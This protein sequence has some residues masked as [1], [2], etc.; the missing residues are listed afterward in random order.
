MSQNLKRTK[1]LGNWQEENALE[2]MMDGKVYDP[3]VK[4][5]TALTNL[6]VIKHTDQVDPKTYS[7]VLKETH[8][9]P[10]SHKDFA[11]R[12]GM[13]PRE[14]MREKMM[15]DTVE[16]EFKTMEAEKERERNATNFVTTYQA[17]FTKDF[18]Q[19]LRDSISGLCSG[20]KRDPY[21]L[22]DP[23]V[24]YY[25]HTALHSDDISF[26]VST[27]GSL[28]QPWAKGGTFSYDINDGRNRQF[29]TFENPG[30]APTVR[31]LRVLR[32][33]REK[34]V[35]ACTSISPPGLSGSTIRVLTQELLDLND[36]PIPRAPVDV[37]AGVLSNL[38]GIECSQQEIDSLVKAFVRYR[39]DRVI[40]VEF[41]EYARGNM[42]PFR[43][44]LVLKAFVSCQPDR[45]GYVSEDS[46]IN[47]FNQSGAEGA[48]ESGLSGGELLNYFLDSLHVYGLNSQAGFE[49]NDFFEYYRDVSCELE[50]NEK[51]ETFVTSTWN[52]DME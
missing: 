12:D 32:N 23:P 8:G 24:T 17:S 9:V 38:L 33:L 25:L 29:G 21:Y 1:K 47:A 40:L 22:N 46:I 15:R 27:I 7:S 26:A 4:T 44:D 18:P 48:S 28:K 50:D 11:R 35:K 34:I 43:A 52:V 13:G 45:D 51:F 49:L 20:Q 36:E 5:S 37:V 10:Q 2:T 3:R 6:R 31:D 42:A 14:R 19:T 30:E 41:I 16:S 39:D